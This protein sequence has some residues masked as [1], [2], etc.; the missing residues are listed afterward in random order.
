MT[1]I[2]GPVTAEGLLAFGR[3]R[4]A[5]LA[6]PDDEADRL[7]FHHASPRWGTRGVRRCSPPRMAGSIPPPAPSGGSRRDHPPRCRLRAGPGRYQRRSHARRMGRARR[8]RLASF[9]A[10]RGRCGL[11]SARRSLV[12][13]RRRRPDSAFV[14]ARRAADALALLQRAKTEYSVIAS[15]RRKRAAPRRSPGVIMADSNSLVTD[16]TPTSSSSPARTGACSEARPETAIKSQS[17]RRSTTMRTAVLMKR[18]G[19]GCLRLGAR[20]RRGDGQ[21]M[22]RPDRRC[23]FDVGR[24]ISHA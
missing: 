4:A 17:S 8:H 22:E 1:R 16:G 3:R 6:L 13:E 19:R 18:D 11:L 20:H 24:G 21:R 14:S 23:E 10:D 15:M 9:G 12:R 2:L 5:G 7:R